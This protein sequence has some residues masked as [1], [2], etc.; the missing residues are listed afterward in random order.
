MINE[1]SPCIYGAKTVLLLGYDNTLEWNSI[2]EEGV[3]SGVVDI[4]IVATHMLLEAA[5]LGVG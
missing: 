5:D 2:F 1:L 3:H 4:S